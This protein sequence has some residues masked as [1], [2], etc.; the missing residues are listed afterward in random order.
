M[1][2]TT[3]VQKAVN[4]EKQAEQEITELA[5]ENGNRHHGLQPSLQYALFARPSRSEQ[6]LNTLPFIRAVAYANRLRTAIRAASRYTAYTSDIGEAFRPVVA[7][8]VVKGAYG[9]SWMYLIGDV[10]Y[11][12][13]KAK[14]QGPSPLD[15][16][17][18]LSENSRLG[19]V[20]A[21]RSIFQ[22]VASMALPAFTIHTA[23]RQAT[24]AFRNASSPRVKA[25]GPTVTGLAI[26]PFLPYLFDHPVETAVDYFF[27]KVEQ[28]LVENHA[29]PAAAVQAVSDEKRDL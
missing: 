27:E 13:Y 22:G 4:L 15:L 24:K 23:V 12:T 11:E 1:S 25:W 21:K 9:V 14:V 18:G 17:T 2:S 6:E 19:M 8:W 28:K 29:G 16:A 5:R 7:P 10:S 26:V 3:T 20:A